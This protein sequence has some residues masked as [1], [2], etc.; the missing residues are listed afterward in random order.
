MTPRPDTHRVLSDHL[1]IEM[2]IARYGHAGRPFLVFPTWRSDYLESERQGLIDAVG[3]LIDGGRVQIFCI[4]SISPLAWCDDA[5]PVPEKVRR[6]GLHS[7]YVE[8][9]VVPWIRDAMGD[10]TA[11]I[12]VGGA[13]FGAFFAANAIFRRPDLFGALLGMSGFYDLAPKLLGYDGGAAYFNNPTWFV[14]NLPDGPAL[15]LLRSD[16]KIELMTGRGAHEAPAGSVA[17][18]SLLEKKGIAHRLDLWGPEM[19]HDWPTWRRMI[20]VGLEARFG[21]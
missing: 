10:P 17:F 16:T 12:G 3:D 20:R 11:R 15:D 6:Q 5:V 14:P 8:Q 9:E 1:G 7:D 2:P 21:W 18:A 4:D 13:S 19:A